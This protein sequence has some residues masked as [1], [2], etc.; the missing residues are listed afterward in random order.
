M[1]GFRFQELF[2]LGDD[3]TPYRKLPGDF[4]R[5]VRAGGREIVQ[6]EP[7]ALA[8]L[9][10]ARLRRHRRTCC[11][12][13]T[14]R[15]S[16]KILDDP[17]ASRQRPLRRAR[18]AH[19]REHRRGPR[20]ARLP[21]HRHR[22]RDRLQGRGRLHR[23]RRRARRSRAGSTTPTSSAT[24]ATR[25]W[26]RSTCTREKNTGTN[27]PAQIEIY[28]EPG[29][30]Y[31]LLFLAK[32]GGS[33]NKTFLYQETKALLNPESLLRFVGREDPHARHLGVPA[34]PPGARDRRD[35]GRAHA[36]DREAREL[37]ATSTTC[38]PAATSSAARSAT[39]RSRSRCS[40]CATRPGSAPSSAASTSR[41]TCA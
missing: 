10:T 22:D 31:H 35:L 39:A 6:V 24:C 20:A 11:A 14:S 26:R 29:D 36:Q 23:R 8:Q 7:E 1:A 17:E 34:L 4:V 37:R 25:R 9:A 15:S 27:L 5:V 16:R 33:A 18:A 32:G 2:E 21:G 38:P 12:R 41:T 19:E 13:G 30:E 3:T 40:S 28:A